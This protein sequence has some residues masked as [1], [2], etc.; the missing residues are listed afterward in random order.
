VSIAQFRRNPNKREAS[1]EASNVISLAVQYDALDIVT[2]NLEDK[3]RFPIS[4]SFFKKRSKNA[5]P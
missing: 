2:F 3:G 1:E 4:S 5:F